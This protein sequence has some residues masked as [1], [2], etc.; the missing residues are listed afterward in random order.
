MGELK[1]VLEQTV[2]LPSLSCAE[3]S[4]Y[5]ENIKQMFLCKVQKEMS[6]ANSTSETLESC[7]NSRAKYVISCH[8]MWITCLLVT[9]FKEGF[10]FSDGYRLGPRPGPRARGL[11]PRGLGP[12]GG[13]TMRF[14]KIFK[15]EYSNSKYNI[16]EKAKNLKKFTRRPTSL[17]ARSYAHTCICASS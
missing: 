4:F 15:K 6:A 3:Q 2:L 1:L 12:R 17:P 13:Q 11:G 9:S 16:S 5:K 7:G 8:V 10:L 14:K